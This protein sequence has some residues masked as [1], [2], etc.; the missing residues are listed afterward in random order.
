MIIERIEV[1]NF[2]SLKNVDVGCDEL[3]VLLGR[4]GAGKSSLLYALDVFYNVAH[5]SEL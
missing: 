3:T 2:R 5:Q 4:N 1:E